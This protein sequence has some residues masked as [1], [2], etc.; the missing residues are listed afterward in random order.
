M[1]VVEGDRVELRE[2]TLV[3]IHRHEWHEIRDT[4]GQSPGTLNLSVSPASR[5]EG[6]ETSEGQAR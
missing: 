2:G 5:P 6:A 4:G 3:L 1:A